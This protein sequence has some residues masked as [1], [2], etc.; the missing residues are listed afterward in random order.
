MQ[1]SLQRGLDLEA[2]VLTEELRVSTGCD[3]MVWGKVWDPKD[4]LSQAS[5]LGCLEAFGEAWGVIV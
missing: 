4:F 1:G 2:W 5:L 3:Q